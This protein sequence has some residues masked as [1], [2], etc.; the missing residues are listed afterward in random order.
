MEPLPEGWAW[1]ALGE[2][3]REPLRNGH[4]AKATSSGD[5][6]RTL[7]L[8][9]VTVGDFSE[10]NTKVTSASQAQAD[11]LWL[12]PGDLF[13]E[14]ANTPELVGTARL[15]RGPKRNCI[16]PDLLVRVRVSN[17]IDARF[18]EAMLHAEPTRRY[19]RRAAQGIA[20]S[21]PKISQGTIAGAVIP[22]PPFAEQRRIVDALETQFT[23]LD[24]AV[25]TLERVRANLKRYRAAVLQAAIEGR[26][27]TSGRRGWETT[28]LGESIDLWAGYGFPERLQGQ[29]DGELP[30]YKVGDIS[31]AW[32]RGQRVLGDAQHYL[33]AAQAIELR[34]T[35]IPA[36]AVVFAKI[37]AAVALNRRALLSRPSLVDNNVFAAIPDPKRIDSAF[38]FLFLCTVQLEKLTRATTVPSLR[39]GD[40]ESIE[41]ALPPLNQQRAIVSVTD[42]LLSQI[43]ASSRYVEASLLRC[44]R[45]RQ[46]LLRLAFDGRL[47]P[48]DP[49]D[50]PASALLD[51]IRRDRAA[52]AAPVKRKPSRSRT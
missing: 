37:G 16:F 45:L 44:S 4:S 31:A 8:T 25:A 9:A 5:G 33:T 52:A 36:G 41:I 30:F 42:Q 49:R 28:T 14:R 7:T 50:E 48:Q 11:G 17:E 27:T 29:A 23:R 3:L 24:A 1:A 34:A 26:F 15:Y 22:L 12:E 2:V 32:R 35:P 13:V 20:G 10:A 21:M 47:A 18:V 43:N 39:K 51:R 40:V 38:L 19:F 46:S 6:V